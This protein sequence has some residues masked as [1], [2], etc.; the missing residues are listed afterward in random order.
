MTK[1]RIP[2][3][4]ANAAGANLVSEDWTRAEG[5]HDRFKALLETS[6]RDR[7]RYGPSAAT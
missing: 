5:A 2:T 6:S 3:D 4:T 7:A 1:R